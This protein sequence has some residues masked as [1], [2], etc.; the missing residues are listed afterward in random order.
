MTGFCGWFATTDAPVQPADLQA[1]RR[2]LV[3]F[4]DFTEEIND[5]RFQIFSR[6]HRPLSLFR[7]DAVIVVVDGEPQFTGDNRLGDTESDCNARSIAKRYRAEPHRF[8]EFLGGNF[9]VAIIDLENS[10]CTLA[11][12][13]L[14]IRPLAYSVSGNLVVF[15]STATSVYEHPAVARGLDRQSLFNYVYFHVIPSPRTIFTSVKKLCPAHCVG[16]STENAKL[17]RYWTPD[18]TRHPQRRIKGRFLEVLGAA[19]KKMSNGDS[20]GAFLSGGLDSSTVCGL[21]Q[22]AHPTKA[23]AFTIGFAQEGYDELEYSRTATKHFGLDLTDYYLT[24]ED[25]LAAIPEVAKAYDEPFGNSSAVPTLICARLAKSAGIENLLAGDGGDELFAGNERY[26]TQKLFSYYR[27]VPKWLDRWLLRPIFFRRS[28]QEKQSG[29]Q[30]KVKRYI[31]Q[32][33]MPMPD[34]TQNYN[35]LQ[36]LGAEAIFSPE[37]LD[38]IDTAEPVNALRDE[39]WQDGPPDQLERL[40]FMDYKFTLADNDLRKVN[41]MCELAGVRVNYPMLDDA[42]LTYS[43]TIPSSVKIKGQNLRAFFKSEAR[44]F[45]PEKIINKTKH[46]FGLPF[47]EWLKLDESLSRHISHNIRNLKERGI[48]R[49][50]FIDDLQRR[51]ETEHA[52]YYGGL[53]WVLAMLEEWLATHRVDL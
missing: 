52:A 35:F 10:R 7:D 12:D 37:F 20:T 26:A 42:V 49:N 28:V 29:F 21:L 24:P 31:E 11:V 4:G 30:H 44:D 47:G 17:Q 34:R 50:S 27:F 1:M 46:G 3:E 18:Y 22:G 19:V 13:R 36:V 5:S 8:P 6:A 41:R 15:G 32:A 39:Y 2:H 14:G 33:T 23:K 53:V 40:L 48:F 43:N 45:L 16:V 9:A 51:H 25:V 38:H